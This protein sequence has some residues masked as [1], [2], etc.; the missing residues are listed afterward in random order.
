MRVLVLT[1]MYPSAQNPA[2][3]IFVQEQVSSLRRVGLDVQ[4]AAISGAKGKRKYLGGFSVFSRH[5]QQFKPDLVHAHHVYCGVI[6]RTQVR[7]PVVLTYHGMEVT[8]EGILLNWLCRIMSRRVEGVIVTSHEL[9]NAI[10]SPDA[11]V[12]P[13]GVD[14]D[15]FQPM[16]RYDAK[17]VIDSL[18]HSRKYVLFTGYFSGAPRRE[19]RLDMVQE[20]VKIA[21]RT[22]PTVELL[23]ISRVPHE[24]MPHYINASHAVILASDHEGS[25]MIIK[26]AMACCTPI[27][28]VP[29]GDVNEVIGGTR[30]CYI[31]ERDPQDMARKILLAT[32]SEDRTNGREKIQ[33]IGLNVIAQK[34][35]G[36]YEHVMR[37]R[38]HCESYPPS[39]PIIYD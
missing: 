17:L 13:C 21:Q 38:G 1:A 12:I 10:G 22:D 31:C 32:Q 33:H 7:C 20:A 16:P 2:Q 19:K 3:G 6:A 30:G 23:V 15:L 8:G 5:L 26:E 35:V 34:V 36:V 25:P 28:S 18:Q 27:V 14:F 9:Y 37:R 24:V 39:E 29:V 11:T 4:V